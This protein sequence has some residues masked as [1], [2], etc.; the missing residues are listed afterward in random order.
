MQWSSIDKSLR[1]CADR[2]GIFDFRLG[3]GI[4]ITGFHLRS[5]NHVEVTAHA[6]PIALGSL[7]DESPLVTQLLAERLSQGGLPTQTEAH[8]HAF[9]W[10]KMLYNCALNPLGALARRPYGALTQE[11]TTRRLVEEVVREMFVVL[12][13]AQIEVAWNTAEEYLATFHED[14]LPPTAEH[15][16]SMLQDLRAGRPT[17]V[18]ALIGAVERLATEHG[19]ETPV[20]SALALLVRSAS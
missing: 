12:D 9:L 1:Q 7:F 11:P 13:A 6:A 15:E 19:V 17:E 5:R 10:A 18:E 20:V 8:M 16:S 4:F 14:L 3:T 2:L